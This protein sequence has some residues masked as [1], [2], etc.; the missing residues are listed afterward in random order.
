MIAMME[1]IPSTAI[2]W[3]L[4]AASVATLAGAF[5]FEHVLGYI[6]CSLCLEGRI[7]HYF[8]IGAAL[9]AGILSREANI[10][11]G[12]LIF[13]SLCIIAYAGAVG[14]SAYHVGVEQKW[15]EGPVACGSGNLVAG[16]L[17]ELQAA[18]QGRVHAP[19]CDEAAW[20][21]FGISLAGFNLLISMAL[22]ALA[23]LPLWRFYRD[24]RGEA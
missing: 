18:L 7:P 15:W 4:V 17:E 1:R 14:I 5:F 10:G 24:S 8:A 23:A 22:G 19:R 9:I 21:L 6:P 12:V 13:L 11:I 3:I 16:S 20:S 2:P